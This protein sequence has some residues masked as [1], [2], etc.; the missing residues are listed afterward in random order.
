V[1]I[2]PGRGLPTPNIPPLIPQ[3]PTLV[4]IFPVETEETTVTP[5]P[6][7][8]VTPVP[9]PTTVTGSGNLTI[10]SRTCD[11]QGFNP[12]FGGTLA[13]FLAECPASDREFEFTLTGAAGSTYTKT[14][15]TSGGVINEVVPAPGVG[16]NRTAVT[17]FDMS[18][19]SCS[20]DSFNKEYPK[21]IAH[22]SGA[23]VAPGES[24]TCYWFN[25][26][27]SADINISVEAYTCP[28]VSPLTTPSVI[29]RT[30]ELDPICTMWPRMGGVT[31]TL[32]D[33][34]PATADQTQV[35]TSTSD[36]QFMDLPA[37][38][39]TITVAPPSGA[40]H[41]YMLSCQGDWGGPTL[42]G[43]VAVTAT[44]DFTFTVPITV[45]G[46]TYRCG[47]YVVKP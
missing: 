32:A 24:V 16:I 5:M 7:P 17:G 14:V 3:T 44:S 41:S 2:L 10:Y 11:N 29:P 19:T 25:V 22:Y 20:N 34:N 23:I 35:T 36:A 39:Y 31:I 15:S 13:T 9:S 38:T 45:T 43:P 1:E 47:L 46:E 42:P 12:H 18:Y 4:P 28:A 30:F 40:T 27:D 33:G 26:L 8:T 6:S 21:A 37:G